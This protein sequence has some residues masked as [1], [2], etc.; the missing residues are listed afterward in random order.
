MRVL[1]VHGLGRTP[2][3][4]VR[5]ARALRRSGCLVE[6]F[7]YLAFAQRYARIVERLVGRLERHAAAGEYAVVGH[8][9]GGILLRDALARL[10][11][12]PPRHLVMLGT[13][14]RPPRASRI[15]VRFPPF[16]WFAGDCGARLASPAFYETL[17]RPAVPY[18]VIA[19]TRGLGGRWSPFA[20][21]PNDG[22]VAVD[23]ARLGDGEDILTFPVA[24]T[25]MM[26]DARVQGAVRHALGLDVR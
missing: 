23:E 6:S 10:S 15:A 9:L 26:N 8:S 16:R 5:L 13:P 11:G 20:G 2:V 21:A 7:P 1:L 22:L 18:T 19:G 14:T 25:F 3:S 4:C 17:P 24:H 12:A